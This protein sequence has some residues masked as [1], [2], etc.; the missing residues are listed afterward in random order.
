MFRPLALFRG[1][2]IVATPVRVLSTE[3]AAAP[4]S[5]L[6]FQDEWANAKPFES[7]PALTK[8]Q[9]IRGFLPG[10]KVRDLL[11]R[12]CSNFNL[13]QGK[14]KKLTMSEMF[15]WELERKW[16]KFSNLIKIFI[17]R[18]QESLRQH[19]ADAWYVRTSSKRHSIWCWGFWKS[20]PVW[21][22]TAIQKNKRHS[23]SLPKKSSAR[24][25]R[26]IRKFD[27]RVS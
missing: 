6:K 23:R 19:R 9:V 26:W 3:P 24:Y 5:E 2:T 27:Y 15:G 21:R 25:L 20:L 18:S 10:G 16:K 8:F 7:I 4:A 1:Q 11:P 17:K 12:N 22:T 13:F 14:F